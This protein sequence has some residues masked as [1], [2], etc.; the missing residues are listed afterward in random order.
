MSRVEVAARLLI[1]AGVTVLI[2]L[3]ALTVHVLGAAP[4]ETVV[5]CAV[6][7]WG[8]FLLSTAVLTVWEWWR[9]N[10]RSNR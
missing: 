5:P 2:G 3:G 1:V 8:W 9:Q 6:L 7:V 4:G 10:R